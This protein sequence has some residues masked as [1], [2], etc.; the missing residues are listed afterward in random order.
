M[1][2]SPS[3]SLVGLKMMI[4]GRSITYVKSIVIIN[5]IYFTYQ[6]K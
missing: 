6:S 3:P 1:K 2:T 4:I 5:M